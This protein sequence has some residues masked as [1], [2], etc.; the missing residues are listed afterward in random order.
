MGA[1]ST[2]RVA[3]FHAATAGFN[4]TVTLGRKST[5]PVYRQRR[6]DSGSLDCR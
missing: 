3:T 5:F 4:F 1:E 6:L 2:I